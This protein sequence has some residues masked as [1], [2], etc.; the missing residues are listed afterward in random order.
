MAGED[1]LTAPTNHDDDDDDDDG[2][3]DFVE[4]QNEMLATPTAD[5]FSWM[6][7]ANFDE[8]FWS[9]LPDHPLLAIDTVCGSGNTVNVTGGH[10]PGTGP[11][12][13]PG[14]AGSTSGIGGSGLKTF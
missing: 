2:S 10:A 8:N 7:Y 11:G 1:A 12:P 3:G 9:S 5:F 13:G 6:D 14:A 4:P